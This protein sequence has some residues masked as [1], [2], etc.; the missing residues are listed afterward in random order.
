M[1]PSHIVIGLFSSF[2]LIGCAHNHETTAATS[3]TVQIAPGSSGTIIL[4]GGE[5]QTETATNQTLTITNGQS[6]TII[7][8]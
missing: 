4:S 1:K 6:G 3:Q 2:F 5:R 8:K 7:L